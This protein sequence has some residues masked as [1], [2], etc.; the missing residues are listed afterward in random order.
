MT[1]SLEDKYVAIRIGGGDTAQ[2]LSLRKRLGLLQQ[3]CALKGRRAIDCGCGAGS[4][5]LALLDLGADAYGIEYNAD[6]VAQYCRMGRDPHR[7]RQGD[8]ERIDYPDEAFDVAL[9][10][11]V[12]EHVPHDSRAVAEVFRILRPGGELAVFSPNR[13]FPFETHGITL[14]AGNLNLP[15]YVPFIAYVPTGLGRHLFR[16]HARNYFPGELVRLIESAGFQVTHRTWLWQTFENISGRQPALIRWT[17]PWLR[18]LAETL[19]RTPLLRRLGVS[20]AVF[21]RKPG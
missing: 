4:Y 14:K 18:G 19:E 21:A 1:K 3:H 5:V 16:F 11:E 17:R 13:L 7:V 10:N 9:L 12:L 15:P 6:K 8:L 2:P 20:Q